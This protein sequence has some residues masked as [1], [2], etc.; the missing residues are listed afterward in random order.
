MAPLGFGKMSIELVMAV[1][2]Q[3]IATGLP[4]PRRHRVHEG[5]QREPGAPRQR[6][7]LGHGGAVD[8]VEACRPIA[9]P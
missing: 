7:H 9:L 3:A 2:T 4:R 1:S 5:R 8:V 6:Q